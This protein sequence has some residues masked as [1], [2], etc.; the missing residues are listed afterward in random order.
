MPDREK[1]I[2]ALECCRYV[3]TWS[4]HNCEICPYKEAGHGVVGCE[5]QLV[6]DALDLLKEQKP[7]VMTPYEV[8][9]EYEIV[10]LDRKNI[11]CE[12]AIL[13]RIACSIYEF[14]IMGTDEMP[15]LLE[16]QYGKTW[17]C[18]TFRPTEEQ[19]RDTKWEGEKE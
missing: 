10:W 9:A 13:Q 18:W 1:V 8:R 12:V 14:S 2:K 16:S 6:S 5:D 15:S 19:M 17:R 7:R 4:F 11:S 3:E